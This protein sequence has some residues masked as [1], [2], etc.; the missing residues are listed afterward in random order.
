MLLLDCGRALTL[1][2]AILFILEVKKV[3]AAATFALGLW[4]DRY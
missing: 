1:S 3:V 2:L 4:L